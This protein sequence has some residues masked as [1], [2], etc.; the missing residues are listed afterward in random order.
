L[1]ALIT[2]TVLASL[3]AG[4][5]VYFEFPPDNLLPW[6]SPETGLFAWF[7]LLSPVAMIFGYLA[8]KRGAPRW[9]NWIVLAVLIWLWLLGCSAGMSV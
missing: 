7:F 4:A 1:I 5:F 6:E 2:A 3:A 9:L 8:S